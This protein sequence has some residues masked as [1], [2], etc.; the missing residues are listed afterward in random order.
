MRIN[1][2]I[3]RDLSSLYM[4][5]CLLNTYLFY[6]HYILVLLLIPVSIYK[7]DDKNLMECLGNKFHFSL[8]NQGNCNGLQFKKCENLR[9][10]VEQ[11]SELK[12]KQ[13]NIFGQC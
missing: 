10:C 11:E 13:G 3:S 2:V 4:G 6:V 1:M 9:L 5:V 8:K 7:L 12:K